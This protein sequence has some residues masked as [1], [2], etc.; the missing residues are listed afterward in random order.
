MPKLFDGTGMGAV[1]RSI[2]R[3]KPTAKP[4]RHQ[5]GGGDLVADL[6][7]QNGRLRTE[8]D[9]WKKRYFLRHEEAQKLEGKL[10][11]R[12]TR[13]AELELELERKQ[14]RIDKLVKK[15]FDATSER[16]PL[17]VETPC[18]PESQQT[19]GDSSSPSPTPTLAK[20]PKKKPR[21]KPPGAPG[22]GPRDH[23]SV[24]LGDE[25]IYEID[26]SCCADCGVQWRE[27]SE[28][29]SDII[30]VEVR[31]YRRRHRRK[32]Y[33]H[34]CKHKKRW[35][36]KRAKG[37]NRLF[38]HAQYGI[39]FWVFLLNG[40]FS[41]HVPVNRLC[42]LLKQKNLSVSQGT[43]AAGFKRIL[44]LIAPLIAEIKRYSREEKSHWH[45]DDAGWKTFVKMDGK[46]GFNWYMWVFRSDDVC[47]YIASP[48]RAREVPKSHLKDSVGVVSCD[49]LQANRKL[50]E[51]L[52][53]AFCWVHERRHFRELHASYPQLRA[54]CDEFLALIG[55]LFHHNKNR[56]FFEQGSAE[57]QKAQTALSDTLSM[58]LK[59]AEELLSNPTI[60]PELRRVLNGVKIDWDGLYTFFELDAIPP[61]NNPAEQALR[62]PIV[63]RNGYYGSGSKWSAEL[64]AAMFSLDKTLSLNKINLEGFLTEYL[65]A[66]AANGGNP[67]PN[68]ANF[69]PWHRKPPPPD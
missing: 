65:E 46:E 64:A 24:S 40:K 11:L 10:S 39:S 32:K 62:G 27:V 13:I 2:S 9:H 28:E 57:Q 5:T 23:D 69:L 18:T 37:P 66:C 45:I 51:S 67:P 33:G 22:Y 50:G 25:S 54:I 49:R 42:T 7:S 38:P 8:R 34:F 30:E 61:D 29:Q 53:Y 3:V 44:R 19:S 20:A 63:G 4:P 26:E 58:I 14:A 68:A 1:K 41:L 6:R 47:V 56:L 21:G 12:D 55:S 35:V 60:H 16:E 17:D 15:L 31:A 48:S 36:T 52:I 43:I 59:R